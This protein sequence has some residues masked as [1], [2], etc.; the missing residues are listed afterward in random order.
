MT[1]FLDA[2]TVVTGLALGASMVGNAVASKIG[3]DHYE[4]E[5]ACS[6]DKEIFDAGHAVIPQIDVSPLVHTL[7]DSFW[8]PFLWFGATHA[9]SAASME[10][11]IR[12]AAIMALRGIT[13]VVTILPKHKS[14]DSERWTWREFFAGQCYDK[15]YSGHAALAVLIS[16]AMVKHGLWPAWLGWGYTWTMVLVLLVSRGHY[17]ID[18][19]LGVVLALLTWHSTLF[20]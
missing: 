19:V 3:R 9:T 17:T 14:C 8:L 4:N 5:P 20:K 10:V 2:R 6:K 7:V 11:G 15:L 1:Q 13:N 18:I 16:L 12:F